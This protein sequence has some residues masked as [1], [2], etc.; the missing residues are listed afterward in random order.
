[1]GD[2][3]QEIYRGQ[4]FKIS[5]DAVQE[6]W[7]VKL[8]FRHFRGMAFEVMFPKREDALWGA[9]R[10]IDSELAYLAEGMPADPELTL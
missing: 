3:H 5:Y 8:F 1:M 6:N 7:F 10:I 9:R 4:G 2:S